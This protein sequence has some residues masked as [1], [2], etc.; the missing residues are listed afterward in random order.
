MLIQST[1]FVE[2]DI[3]NSLYRSIL[4]QYKQLI[5]LKNL[6]TSV[7]DLSVPMGRVSHLGLGPACVVAVRWIRG[8]ASNTE[9][10]SMNNYQNKLRLIPSSLLFF[11]L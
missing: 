6:A 5:I 9:K 8:A 2:H 3:D 7:A 10:T 4:K 11:L 1:W